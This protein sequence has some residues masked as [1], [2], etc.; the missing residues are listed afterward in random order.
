MKDARG[1]MLALRRLP[2]FPSPRRPRY[3]HELP[4]QRSRGR[5]IF[6]AT[7]TVL[8]LAVA[9]AGGGLAWTRW[10]LSRVPTFAGGAPVPGPGAAAGVPR[11]AKPL[12]LPAALEGVTTFLV[13]STGSEGMTAEEAKQYGVTD[14]AARGGDGLTDSIIVAVL[15][16]SDRQMSLLSIPRDTWLDWR[17]R[18]INETYRRDGA[19]AFASDVTRLTG[20]PI[21]HMIAVSFTAA[22]RLA[23]AVG[24]IDVQI[25]TPMRDDKSHLLLPQ[26]GCIHMDGRVALAFARS[27][28]TQTQGPDGW[29]TD[30]SASD[31]G[32]NTRQQAV[33]VAAL[34]KLLTPR[35]PVLLP[36]L[37][38]TAQQTLTIDA[39]LDLGEIF[40]TG[41]VLA[42]G[43]ALTIHHYGLPSR[44]TTIGGASVVLPDAARAGRVLE[45][46]LAAVPGSRWPDWVVPVGASSPSPSG[47]PGGPPAGGSSDGSSTSVIG[48][49]SAVSVE[50]YELGSSASYRPCSNGITPPPQP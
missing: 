6:T 43:R 4:R 33:I 2:R 9:V 34:D 19:T 30:P 14:L 11:D 41:R 29:R 37:A 12:Q 25:P 17:G 45:P 46:L 23:D 47:T 36:A 13:F 22:G 44:V 28:H 49:D 26:D 48:K 39:G 10:Q 31:F 16:A 42:T 7:L 8:V 5:V 3:Q 38:R 15:D 35:L 27:R 18:R 24:G 32:R 50:G 20:L 40:D 21:N 1:H